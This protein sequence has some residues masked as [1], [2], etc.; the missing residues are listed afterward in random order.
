MGSVNNISEL[1]NI[2]GRQFKIAQ[3]GLKMQEI[4][5]KYFNSAKKIEYPKHGLEIWPGFF[6][7]VKLVDQRV[8]INVDLSFKIIRYFYYQLKIQL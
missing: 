4:G 6:S 3:K 8:F 2:L 7:S 1:L 5:R